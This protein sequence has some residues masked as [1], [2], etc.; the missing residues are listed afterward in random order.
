[1]CCLFTACMHFQAG[2]VINPAPKT[3][4][5]E[6]LRQLQ[7]INYATNQ[8]APLGR[9]QVQSPGLPNWLDPEKTTFG[10][11]ALQCKSNNET[12]LAY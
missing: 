8:K 6:R 4:F 3:R 2:S 1:M 9:S 12:S 5:L 11:T 7:E 10:V